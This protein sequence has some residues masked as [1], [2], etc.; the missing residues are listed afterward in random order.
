MS[1]IGYMI[2]CQRCEARM[3]VTSEAKHTQHCPDCLTEAVLQAIESAEVEDSQRKPDNAG[4]YE[5]LLPW[6]LELLGRNDD[7]YPIGEVQG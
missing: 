5:S 2:S 4:P 3:L 7:D 1:V 6:E